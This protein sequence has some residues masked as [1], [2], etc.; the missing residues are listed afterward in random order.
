MPTYIAL[1]NWTDQGGGGEGVAGRQ[2]LP[3]E[4]E[5]VEHQA[6]KST[7]G[8][9]L[10]IHGDILPDPTMAISDSILSNTTRS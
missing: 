10:T 9:L 7:T 8:G 4:P 2:E 3:I 5:H 1:M 6:G